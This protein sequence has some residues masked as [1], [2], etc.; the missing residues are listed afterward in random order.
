MTLGEEEDMGD[1]DSRTPVNMVKLAAVPKSLRV[2][3]AGQQF[4]L[5]R[6][7]RALNCIHASS[8]PA[9]KAPR[10]EPFSSL[11][12]NQKREKKG[13]HIAALPR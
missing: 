2:V 5:V 4:G 11:S 10:R 1:H 12:A 13:D 8:A 6:Y 7:C 9:S 3:G